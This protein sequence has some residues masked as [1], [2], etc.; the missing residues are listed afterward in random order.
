VH[1]CSLPSHRAY[2]SA[3][4]AHA[5]RKGCQGLPS[6]LLSFTSLCPFLCP[7]Q[8]QLAIRVL[9]HV[10]LVAYMQ[11]GML[12]VEAVFGRLEAM[13]P[14]GAVAAAGSATAAGVTASLSAAEADPDAEDTSADA[15]HQQPSPQPHVH[16]LD[17]GAYRSSNWAGTSS[18]GVSLFPPAPVEEPRLI[19]CLPA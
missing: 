6:F 3:G 9:H 4:A 10:H 1:C 14:T 11:D 2:L 15:Q 19:I 13:P 16:R 8:P 12:I 17:S 7:S 5:T 18:A